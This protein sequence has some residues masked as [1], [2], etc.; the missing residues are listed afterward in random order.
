MEKGMTQAPER[1][2]EMKK[3]KQKSSKTDILT[4]E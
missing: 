1:F 2:P 3:K 4:V